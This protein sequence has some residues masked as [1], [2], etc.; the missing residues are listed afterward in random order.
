MLE[1]KIPP[2]SVVDDLPMS[3]NRSEYRR[4]RRE[5]IVSDVVGKSDSSRSGTLK[6][7][8]IGRMVSPSIRNDRCGSEKQSCRCHF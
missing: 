8:Y 7:H 1:W 4:R 6:E 3:E 2:V 5:Q